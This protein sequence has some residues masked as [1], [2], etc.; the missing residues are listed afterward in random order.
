MR[1]EGDEIGRY[2]VLE[3]REGRN[4]VVYR[5]E[6]LSS[7]AIV[8]L[9]QPSAEV[10]AEPELLERYRADAR[11]LQR[12]SS[13][14]VVQFRH[15]YD[16]GD[17]DDGCYLEMEWAGRSLQEVID[18]SERLAAPTAAALLR[19][20]L[21]GLR[22][23]HGTFVA[24]RNLRPNKLLITGGPTTLRI[25]DLGLASGAGRDFT[26]PRQF[27]SFE[28]SAPEL[29]AGRSVGPEGDIYALG[30]IFLHLILEEDKLQQVCATP[31]AEV[32]SS[33]EERWR[34]W[35][36]DL[37]C[38][39]PPLEELAPDLPAGLRAALQGMV[40]KRSEDRL[41]DAGAVLAL[42]G[43]DD[44]QARDGTESE[45]R[46]DANGL[47]ADWRMQA[48]AGALALTVGSLIFFGLGGLGDGGRQ[49]AE[50]ARGKMVAR[51]KLLKEAAAPDRVP[52]CYAKLRKGGA[53]AAE[54]FKKGDFVTARRYYLATHK[55]AGEC[56]AEL[57]T[58]IHKCEKAEQILAAVREGAEAAG[59][60]VEKLRQASALC[61][62]NA[63]VLKSLGVRLAVLK[64]Y[65]EAKAIL[66]QA[67][68]LGE[69]AGVVHDLGMVALEVGEF[70]EAQRHFEQAIEL[71]P[72]FSQAHVSL[73]RLQRRQG[74]CD[75]A[76]AT[77]EAALR[78]K[79]QGCDRAEQPGCFARM[80]GRPPDCRPVL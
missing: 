54:E 73:G 7:G 19:T 66:S 65:D 36:A 39:L 76:V 45:D 58:L 4:A 70:D 32:G 42:L 10:V 38:E 14:H 21:H 26:P 25:A 61:P 51:V 16:V 80:S 53:A 35:H 29:I 68:E 20:S 3:R 40:C 79:T 30:W 37:N 24:H 50:A 75:E 8:A 31:D 62:T 49:A 47:F 63:D 52:E 34:A 72:A 56:E 6:D 27:L 9:K 71:D 78:Q 41:R 22:A 60:Q 18:S 12:V 44:D 67:L 59:Q 17:I 74:K 23:I 64:K 55:K 33:R 5:C 46:P 1:S 15:F 48:G 2:R 13:P 11:N 57:E 28:Y 77:F 43:S 69:D